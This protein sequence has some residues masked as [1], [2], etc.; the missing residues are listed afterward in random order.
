MT[1]L[2]ASFLQA[3][4]AHRA[5]HDLD[6]AR[7]ENSLSAIRAAIEG[8]YGIEID[9]Q[10]SSDRV[11][12]VFHDYDLHRLTG[13]RGPVAQRH[14]HELRQLQLRGSN[15]GIPTLGDALELVNGRVPVLIEVK[16]QDGAMGPSVGALERAVAEEVATYSGDVALMS[17]NP[18]SVEELASLLPGR[19]L[20][21]VTCDFNQQDWPLLPVDTRNRLRSVPDFERLGLGF[22]SHQATDLANPRVA[23]IKSSGAA[24]LCWTVRSE[25][26][27]ADARQFA[28]NITFEGY[29]PP[30]DVGF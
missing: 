3:P 8:G 11:A 20:G 2:P 12:M 16:D 29:T 13:E 15:E 18:H 14:A 26:E 19:P 6:K 5:L 28:D 23:E 17:F 24:I 4:I 9:V 21:L 27:E 30:F 7:P 22:V 25:A 1:P 10:P